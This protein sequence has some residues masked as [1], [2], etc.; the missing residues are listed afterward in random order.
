MGVMMLD[1]E[2]QSEEEQD[3]E[4]QL[5]IKAKLGYRNRGDAEGDWKE[6]DRAIVLRS[7]NCEID[8]ELKREG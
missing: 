3:P 4:V 5:F 7:L 1:I 2:Y 6:L 8:E